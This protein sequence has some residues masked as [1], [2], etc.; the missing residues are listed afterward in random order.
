MAIRSL[1]HKNKL[2]L[3]R[4]WLTHNGWTIHATKGP[5]EVLRATRD[6]RKYPLIVYEK[7]HSREHLS[8]QESDIAVVKK[9][10]RDLKSGKATEIEEA[11]R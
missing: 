7:L 2:P 10:L 8:V 6:G 9:F 11:D 3:L 5:Y 1:L 4:Y